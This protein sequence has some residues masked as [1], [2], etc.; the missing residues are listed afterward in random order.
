MATGTAGSTAR[1]FHTQQVHYLRKTVAYNTTNIANG[2]KMGTLPAGAKVIDA[3]VHV[4]TAFNAASTNVLT[5]GTNST[6]YDNIVGSGDVTEGT[7]AG[8]RASVTTAAAQTL[9]A[10]TDVY[11][12]YTQTGTAASTGAATVIITYVPDNDG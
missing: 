10:D 1:Q 8:Y 4:T 11:V 12:K 6:S 5:A 2:I 3:V 7:P 9:S